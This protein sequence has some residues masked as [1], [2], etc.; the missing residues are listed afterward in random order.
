VTSIID[1]IPAAPTLADLLAYVDY[2]A[3]HMANSRMTVD[4]AQ[5]LVDDAET[6]Q[7]RWLSELVRDR[8]KVYQVAAPWHLYPAP[9]HGQKLAMLLVGVEE[10]EC[11]S[12]IDG[13]L[14][15]IKADLIRRGFCEKVAADWAEGLAEDA[16]WYLYSI[17]HAGGVTVGMA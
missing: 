2:T 15:P 8:L 6:P 16:G 3:A 7:L 1:L 10:D 17:E 5:M 9:E 4:H 12:V 13:Y 11:E 14:N